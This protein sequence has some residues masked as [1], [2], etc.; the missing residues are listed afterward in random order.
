MRSSAR[1]GRGATLTPGG[2]GT[3]PVRGVVGGD[4]AV[5][6]PTFDAEETL[7]RGP[8]VSFFSGFTVVPGVFRVFWFSCPPSGCFCPEATTC[9]G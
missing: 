6:C 1:P 7:R 5:Q 9:P 2:E 8:V 4:M 3:E